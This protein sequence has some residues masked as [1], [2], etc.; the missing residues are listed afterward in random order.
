MIQEFLNALLIQLNEYE[1][2][3][4]FIQFSQNLTC[5]CLLIFVF[6]PEFTWAEPKIVWTS[7]QNNFSF[8]SGKFG[9]KTEINK[10]SYVKLWLNWINYGADSYS[11]GCTLKNYTISCLYKF[12]YWKKYLKHNE[13]GYKFFLKYYFFFFLKKYFHLK[14]GSMYGHKRYSNDET[15]EKLH[16]RC[17]I[18]ENLSFESVSQKSNRLTL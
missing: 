9:G 3:P 17:R 12:N 18:E 11:L 16:M 15:T 6:P 1:T 13:R 8:S 7:E 4:Y 10:E 5:G 14:K 2:A